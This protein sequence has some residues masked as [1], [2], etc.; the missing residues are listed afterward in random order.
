MPDLQAPAVLSAGEVGKADECGSQRRGQNKVAFRSAKVVHLF[1]RTPRTQMNTA[2]NN[3]VVRTKSPF[4]PRKL[5]VCSTKN[6]ADA[7]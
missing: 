3:A 1:Q 7:R 4:A 2:N 6:H 5:C